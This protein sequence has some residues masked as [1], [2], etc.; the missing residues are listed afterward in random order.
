MY[1]MSPGD[2]D[3][4][5]D[6]QDGVC[7]ICQQPETAQQKGRL[8]ELCVD[9]NHKTGQVRG[10]LCHKCNLAIGHFKDDAALVA[11][12]LQYLGGVA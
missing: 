3:A 5:F 4:L 9:H 10:L 6:I 11:K 7:A 12:A 1:G 2:Y 8:R